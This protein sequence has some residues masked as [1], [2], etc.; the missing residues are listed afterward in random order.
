MFVGT[1]FISVESLLSI[2]LSADELHNF[3]PS[4]AHANSFISLPPPPPKASGNLVFKCMSI[5]HLNHHRGV[6]VT[7]GHSIAFSKH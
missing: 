5:P 4:A 3:Y 1:L 7:K 2:C 6:N